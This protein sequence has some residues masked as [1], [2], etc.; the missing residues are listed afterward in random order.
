MIY[1]LVKNIGR[2]FKDFF[3]ISKY[4]KEIYGRQFSQIDKMPLIPLPLHHFSVVYVTVM[5]CNL[6]A[7]RSEFQHCNGREGGGGGGNNIEIRKVYEL[8]SRIV[9]CVEL[10]G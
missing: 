2:L 7:I 3:K 10:G 5:S 8:F 6:Q 4:V 9:L 1:N